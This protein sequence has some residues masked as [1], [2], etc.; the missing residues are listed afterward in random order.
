MAKRRAPDRIDAEVARLRLLQATD[1]ARALEYALELIDLRREH[2]ALEPALAALGDE[3]P[4]AARQPLRRRWLDLTENGDR[5]DQDCAL[6]VAILRALRGLD[7]RADDDVA[8]AAARTVQ[9][10]MGVDVA[11]GLR[12]EGLLLLA[13]SSPERADLL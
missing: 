9:I 2:R 4:P 10:R 8:E 11:Q 13:E 1:P 6:R 12:A 7:S 3:P 5:A